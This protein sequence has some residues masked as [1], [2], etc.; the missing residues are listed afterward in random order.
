MGQGA[1][2]SMWRTMC[3]GLALPKV[4]ASQFRPPIR[5]DGA[6]HGEPVLVIPGLMSGDNFTSFL[7]RSLVIS[8]FD[9]RPSGI[10][11][12][13]G[14]T[15]VLIE[16]LEKLVAAIHRE[17]GET[18]TLLGWSL[19]GLYA[20]LLGIRCAEHVRRVVTL[21]SPFSGDLRANHGW[22]LYE[23]LNQ[24][25]VDD[26]QF[27]EDISAKPPVDTIAV[28]SPNDGIV[29]PQSSRGLAE[30]SDRQIEVS[31]THLEMGSSATCV[32]RIIELLGEVSPE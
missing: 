17:T 28:W 10:L 1:P 15:P 30:E 18:V 14:A 19:G 25:K 7:R 32:R 3:E 6:G 22:R 8:G 20:R 2:P 11:I 13:T 21:G 4:A 16:R 29:S 24:H 27:A 9:A 5:V 26:P 31:A 23:L 12:N